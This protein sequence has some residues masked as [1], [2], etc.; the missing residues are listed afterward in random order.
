MELA[1]YVRVDRRVLATC[2]REP[3]RLDRLIEGQLRTGRRLDLGQAWDGLHY[4]LSPRRRAGAIRDTGDPFGLALFGGDPINPY[5][6]DP[7]EIVRAL[8]S[9]AVARIDRELQKIHAGD[10]R[11]QYDCEAMDRMAVQPADW[12]TRGE[13]G[14]EYLLDAFLQWRELYHLAAEENLAVICAVR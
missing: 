9:A 4:L 2:R 1:C 5:A 6:M 12:A 14:F 11:R 3:A 10:L 13:E 8:E 7:A